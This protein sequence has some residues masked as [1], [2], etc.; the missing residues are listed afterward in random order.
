[1]NR[2]TI[3]IKTPKDGHEVV[4]KEWLTAREKRDIS[5]VFL[6]KA[7]FSASDKSFDVDGALLNELQDTQVKNVVISI[8]GKTEDP[9]EICL[10]MKSEDYEFIL[11]KIEKIVN[12]E[13]KK[14]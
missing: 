5:S 10:D 9:L 4:L 13:V 11:E 2:D 6:S 14:K 12:P 8:D 7:K 1:M 3:T